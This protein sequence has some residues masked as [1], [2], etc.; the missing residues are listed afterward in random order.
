[1]GACFTA[2]A[3]MQGLAL[4]MKVSKQELTEQDLT[5]QALSREILFP[6]TPTVLHSK[7][8]TTVQK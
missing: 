7:Y 6:K 1:M 4:E 2:K 8:Q 3:K 5:A